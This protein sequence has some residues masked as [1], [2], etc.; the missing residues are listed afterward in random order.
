[1]FTC[2]GEKAKCE[3]TV[4]RRKAEPPLPPASAAPPSTLPLTTTAET[5]RDHNKPASEGTSLNC[6][7]GVCNSVH[8]SWFLHFKIKTDTGLWKLS[9]WISHGFSGAFS[10][11]K[12]LI[13]NLFLFKF[14]SLAAGFHI[15]FQV[16]LYETASSEKGV[17]KLRSNLWAKTSWLTQS[18]K[19]TG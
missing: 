5:D 12:S 7:G 1:M 9:G 16:S 15:T 19:V 8:F 18:V 17:Q 3:H 14:L 4:Q 13:L 11:A 2:Q 6:L 10:P